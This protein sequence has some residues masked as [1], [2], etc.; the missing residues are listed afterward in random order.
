MTINGALAL[1]G[2]NS[3]HPQRRRGR[4]PGA[5]SK[6]SLDLA[7]WIESQFAGQTPGQQS[8][9]MCMV[10]PGDLKRAKAQAQELGIVDLGLAPMMLAMVVK[11]AQ[12]GKA[13]DCDRAQAWL[14]LQ[15]ARDD[16]MPYIHQRRPAAAEDKGK[17]PA[18]AFFIPDGAPPGGGLDFSLS[19][20][21]DGYEII[22]L[23]PMA[24]GEVNPPKSTT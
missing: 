19:A 23:S 9:M 22:E 3:P 16:L 11:A 7:R 10:S 5:K 6:R 4:P 17:Q 8:A 21:D 13:L 12:L 18:M 20:D 14:L 1:E 24:E 2:P 15:K